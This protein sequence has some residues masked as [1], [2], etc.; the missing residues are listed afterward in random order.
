MSLGLMFNMILVMSL[1][2]LYCSH[3]QH[4]VFQVNNALH[5]FVMVLPHLIDVVHD[6]LIGRMLGL[7]HLEIRVAAYCRRWHR[8]P[9]HPC[10]VLVVN[11]LGP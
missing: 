3:L 8:G 9:H 4:E 11:L 10:S 5:D 1:S 7:E 2:L 6:L